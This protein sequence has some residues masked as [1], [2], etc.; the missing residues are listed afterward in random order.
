MPHP[1]TTLLVTHSLPEAIFLADRVAILTPRP[2]RLLHTLHVDLPRP[3][4]QAL[5]DTPY[6]HALVAQARHLL[7]SEIC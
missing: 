7:R 2:G 4:D 3:R 1:I 6:F 5:R